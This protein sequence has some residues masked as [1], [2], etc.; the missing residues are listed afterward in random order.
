MKQPRIGVAHL[1]ALEL[2]PA[3]LIMQ[4]A[5][6]GFNSV[7]IRTNPVAPGMP[8]Y[9]LKAGTDEHRELVR[10]L[11]DNG[12]TVQEVEFIS[13]VPELDVQSYATMFEAAAGLGAQAVTVSGDDDDFSRLVDSLGRLCDLAAG[14]DLRIDL[15]PMRWRHVGNIGA[16]RRVLDAAARSNGAILVDALHLARSGSTPAELREFPASRLRAVQICDAPAVAP[17][18]DD[19]TIREAREGRLPPGQGA[20][21]LVDLLCSLPDDIAISAEMP[22]KTLPVLERLTLAFNASNDLIQRARKER[23]G[24]RCN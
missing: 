3:A 5:R 22:F 1:T 7:G 23:T 13:I 19:A 18:G 8:C 14:F 2:A 16:A 12:M 15:E 24:T 4:S 6:A 9:P 20:L 21:P 10:L 11:D 17:I